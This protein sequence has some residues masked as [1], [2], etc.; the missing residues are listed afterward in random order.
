MSCS[1]TLPVFAMTNVYVTGSPAFWTTV[2][3]TVLLSVWDPRG[4]VSSVTVARAVTSSAGDAGSP[5]GASALT[6]AAFAMVPVSNPACGTVYRAVH[7]RDAPGARTAGC[8][9]SSADRPAFG[10]TT[11]TPLRVTLPVLRATKV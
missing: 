2:G 10:S 5:P 7:V 1:V 3:L 4:L 11:V 9:Q 8:A 6:V